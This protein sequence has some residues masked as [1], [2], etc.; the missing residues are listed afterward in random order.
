MICASVLACQANAARA[1]Q[2]LRTAAMDTAKPSPSPAKKWFIVN[3]VIA[4]ALCTAALGGMGDVLFSILA[5]EGLWGYTQDIAPFKAAWAMLFLGVLSGLTALFLGVATESWKC[6]ILLDLAAFAF[7]C[8]SFVWF[9][10]L[11][12]PSE[13]ADVLEDYFG[14]PFPCLRSGFSW[15]HGVNIGGLINYLF[16]ALNAHVAGQAK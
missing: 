12:Y 16:A 10:P 9:S 15:F 7:V 6:A 14:Y 5:N 4:L 11:C 3:N 8:L 13:V 1:N 2:P